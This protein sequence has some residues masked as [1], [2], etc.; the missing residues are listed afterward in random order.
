MTQSSAF[1]NLSFPLFLSKVSLESFLLRLKI[2]QIHP[3]KAVKTD[4]TLEYNL[5]ILKLSFRASMFSEF[6]DLL[7]S[8]PI[9]GITFDIL[10]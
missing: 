2:L 10:T 7:V 6:S 9:R 1:T 3:N 8:D 5:V 4:R